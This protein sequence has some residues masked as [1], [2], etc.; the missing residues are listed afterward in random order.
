MFIGSQALS[1][2]IFIRSRIAWSFNLVILRVS[3]GVAELADASVIHPRDLG[4]NLNADKKFL[5]LF[6]S[7]L[8]S[9]LC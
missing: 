9:Y 2:L 5:T 3:G 8:N 4:S 6:A 7:I 1:W